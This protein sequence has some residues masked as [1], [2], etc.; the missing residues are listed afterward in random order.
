MDNSGSS[1]L[2]S[3]ACHEWNCPLWIMGKK[4]LY[5]LCLKFTNLCKE[6]Y[7]SHLVFIG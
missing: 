7:G 6:I 3:K 5:E 1:L 4:L 2:V